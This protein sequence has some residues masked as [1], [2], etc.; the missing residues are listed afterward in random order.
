MRIRN[1]KNIIEYVCC[2]LVINLLVA[3]VVHASWVL[4]AGNIDADSEASQHCAQMNALKIDM[5]TAVPESLPGMTSQA[6]CEHGSA[7]KLLCSVAASA[8]CHQSSTF[9]FVKS[10]RWLPDAAPQLNASFQPRLDKP[11]RF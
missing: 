10:T 8:L 3:P 9:D 6:E 1:R 4:P 7:C 11:P 2:L 5:D